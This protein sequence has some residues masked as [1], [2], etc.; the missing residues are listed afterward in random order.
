[1]DNP[2]K[3]SFDLEFKETEE[4]D[5]PSDKV[6]HDKAFDQSQGAA[7]FLNEESNPFSEE[8]TSE[9]D[10]GMDEAVLS[11]LNE[12]QG[13]GS[14]YQPE[15]VT[16][17]EEEVEEADR[18]AVEDVLAHINGN[19]EKQNEDRDRGAVEDVLQDLNSENEYGKNLG[20]I[21]EEEE[22]DG[23]VPEE[24]KDQQEGG[25]EEEDMEEAVD[26]VLNQVL[27]EQQ[28][29]LHEDW[30]QR[31]LEDEDPCWEDHTMVGTKMQDGEEV[32]NCVPEDEAEDYEANESVSRQGSISEDDVMDAVLEDQVEEL[33]RLDQLAEQVLNG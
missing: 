26:A 5:E 2:L 31:V 28:E 10:E 33:S 13:G 14:Q 24:F 27:S 9:E 18:G 12:A 3:R 22:E 30:K 1:M 25:E 11:A 32:P 4:T 19:Y 16:Q 7:S 29:P 15:E 20:D 23:D 6:D 8:E 21:F 17:E